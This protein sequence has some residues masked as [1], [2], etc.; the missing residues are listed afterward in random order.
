LNVIFSPISLLSLYFRSLRKGGY[1]FIDTHQTFKL[2]GYPYDYY[3]FSR[4]ALESLFPNNFGLHIIHSF[5]HHETR[6]YGDPNAPG[7]LLPTDGMLE[8]GENSWLSVC[9]LGRKKKQ[10]SGPLFET[11][12]R[13]DLGKR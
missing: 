8:I 10:S 1:L 4:E 7:T 2:H 6:Y 9:L 5:Y 11:N 12:Y 3:R 13:F